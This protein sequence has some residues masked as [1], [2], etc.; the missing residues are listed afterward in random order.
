M[1][2]LQKSIFIGVY[3]QMDLKSATDQKRVPL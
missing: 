3:K 2:F 1:Y